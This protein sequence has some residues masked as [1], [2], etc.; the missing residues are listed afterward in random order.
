M[1][2]PIGWPARPTFDQTLDAAQ[3]IN[4]LLDHMRGRPRVPLLSGC[5]SPGRESLD[6]VRIATSVFA[7]LLYRV[8]IEE[9]ARRI[10]PTR[11]LPRLLGCAANRPHICLND[12]D[13]TCL[14]NM[15]TRITILVTTGLLF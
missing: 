14:S 15:L 12:R 6:E 10:V 7:E 1:G 8:R 3:L 2:R 11:G 5:V 9:L 4:P 13:K